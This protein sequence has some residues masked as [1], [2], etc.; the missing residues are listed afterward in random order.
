MYLLLILSTSGIYLWAVLKAD[1]RTGLLV[2]GAG[3]LSFA[4]IVFAVVA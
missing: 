3:V 4:A 2:L 1:R